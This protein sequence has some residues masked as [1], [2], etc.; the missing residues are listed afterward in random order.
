MNFSIFC[1]N[2]DPSAPILNLITFIWYFVSYPQY[3]HYE[4]VYYA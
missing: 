2:Q 1:N 3:E 4:N